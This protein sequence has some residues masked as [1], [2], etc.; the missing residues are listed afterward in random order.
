MDP[1]YNTLGDT[2]GEIAALELAAYSLGGLTDLH[3]IRLIHEHASDLGGGQPPSLSD[4]GGRVVLLPGKV[5]GLVW[6]TH[7]LPNTDG[8]V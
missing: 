3:H 1:V 4:L 6:R 7:L 8:R 2:Q 5:D